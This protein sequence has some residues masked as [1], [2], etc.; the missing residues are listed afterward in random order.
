MWNQDVYE[1]IEKELEKN[2][3]EEDVDEFMLELAECLEASESMD[4]EV[5]KTETY[6]KTQVLVTGICTLHEEEVNVLIKRI[7]I[8]KNEFEINDYLL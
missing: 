6:G 7:K 2:N 1:A 3:I 8:G 4:K 5:S